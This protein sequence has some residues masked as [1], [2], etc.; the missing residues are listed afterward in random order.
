[1][2]LLVTSQDLVGTKRQ[3]PVRRMLLHACTI[4]LGR[5]E[6]L[7]RQ[8]DSK[9]CVFWGRAKKVPFELV[10][11]GEVCGGGSC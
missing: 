8:K 10:A 11:F 6:M 7:S 2:H 3:T 9:N 5:G 1:M 4:A